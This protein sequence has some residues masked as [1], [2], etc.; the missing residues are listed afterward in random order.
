MT[1][2]VCYRT[3]EPAAG[4]GRLTSASWSRA[5]KTQRFVDVVGGTPGLYE[6]RSALLWDDDGLRVGFWCESPFV[7]AHVTERDDLVCVESDVEIFIDGGDAYYELQVNALNT[8]YEV[9]YVWKDAYE[10]GGRYDVPE[11]D[12]RRASTFAGNPEPA[13]HNANTFWTG[14]HPRG[15]RWAFFDWDLPGLTTA[16]HVDGT[17]NDSSSLDRGWT[18]EVSFPW[19]GLSLLAGDRALPPS[20]G[21]SWRVFLARYEKLRIGGADVI[22]GWTTSPIGGVDNHRPERFMAVEFSQEFVENRRPE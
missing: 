11:L 19:S 16:V 14:N 6:T 17:I 21:D 1:E 9:L 18:V 10:R 22:V 8:I 15:N 13:Q 20:P 3:T 2:Y 7:E 12:V 4:D 5:P